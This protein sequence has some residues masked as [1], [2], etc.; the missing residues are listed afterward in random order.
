MIALVAG[1]MFVFSGLYLGKVPVPGCKTHLSSDDFARLHPRDAGPR[2]ALSGGSQNMTLSRH[3][4]SEGRDAECPGATSSPDRRERYSRIMV[5]PHMSTEDITWIDDELPGLHTIRYT[6][7]DVLAPHHPPMNKGH[8]VVIYLSFILEH[9][10]NLPDVVIFMHAHRYSHHNSGLLGFDAVQMLKRL[11]SEHVV[12]HGYVN[13]RCDWSPGCP[14]WLHPGAAQEVLEKQEE[15]VLSDIWRELFPERSLPRTL[16][17][18]CCAQFAISRKAIRSM[19]KSRY[20]FFR[21]WILR[22]PLNDYVSGRIWEYCW[23]SLFL[24][25]NTLCPNE[26]VCHCDVFAVCFDG[27][28]KYR[29]YKQLQK[30]SERYRYEFD[31]MERVRIQGL[32]GEV[33]GGAGT[34]SNLRRSLTVH[35][36]ILA[37]EKESQTQKTEALERGNSLQ[38][39]SNEGQAS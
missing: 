17:Q 39:N 33:F 12:R 22:T 3:C 24:N 13:M 14:E 27:H 35:Q 7:N 16:A 26:Y 9:Y 31:G 18:P 28:D 11:S 6:A 23:Q 8:E 2:A 15:V 1:L 21:D 19:P 36:R 34:Q 29:A 10:E 32:G 4:R 37:I 20:V 30:E 25:R 5:V 38:S